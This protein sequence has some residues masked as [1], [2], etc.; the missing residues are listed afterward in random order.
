M[1]LILPMA[2]DV[3]SPFGQT[4]AQ[5]RIVRQRN[6]RYGSCGLSSSTLLA[7]PRLST[8]KR[9]AC[10]SPAEPTYLSGFL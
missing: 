6:S 8:K 10:R 3:F 5:L 9:Y 2:R 1:S 7:W 4:S